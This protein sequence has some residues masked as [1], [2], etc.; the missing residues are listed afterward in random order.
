MIISGLQLDVF[1]PNETINR[2]RAKYPNDNSFG[3]NLVKVI[4][5]VKSIDPNHSS[6]DVYRKVLWDTKQLTEKELKKQEANPK[7]LEK[8]MSLKDMRRIWKT[9]PNNSDKLIIGF[10][11]WYPS[12]RSDWAG[13]NVDDNNFVF[14]KFLKRQDG[15]N[16]GNLKK[17]IVPELKPLLDY[18]PTLPPRNNS[19]V[20]KLG[21]ATKKY[22]GKNISVNMFRKIWAF[23]NK[24]KSMLQREELA[25]QMNHTLGVAN[26]HYTKLDLN[27][28]KKPI[29]P[30]RTTSTKG[31]ETL[32]I[33]TETDKP[34]EQPSPPPIK[35][36]NTK[37]LI[38]KFNKLNIK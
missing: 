38:D 1:F 8:Y 21:R 37:V 36:R 12:L 17:P 30:K 27:K 33:T 32:I 34:F 16:Q 4:N 25:K 22:F 5:R 15:D 23:E 9:I 19:F 2:L 18:V 14:D 20:V 26:I 24:N 29:P 28:N 35:R 7:E 11:I 31:K 6:L 3:T 13:V 10:Y